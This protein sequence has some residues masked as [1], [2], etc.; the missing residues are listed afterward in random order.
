MYRIVQGANVIGLC[1]KPRYVKTK[2]GIY[3]EASEEDATHV[4]VQGTTY[5]LSEVTITQVDSGEVAFNQSNEIKDINMS[6]EELT[7]YTET[8]TAYIGDTE[9]TF[10]TDIKGNLTVYFPYEYSVERLSDR[11]FIT[12][13]PLEEVTDITI[14]IL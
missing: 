8:Q 3:I 10:Y 2:E 13:D 5:L 7:P 12:F 4:A 1:D 9:K 14:S 6:V 11:I